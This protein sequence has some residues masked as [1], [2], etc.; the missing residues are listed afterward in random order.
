MLALAAGAG[1]AQA[2]QLSQPATTHAPTTVLSGPPDS[3][4]PEKT[5]RRKFISRMSTYTD[6]TRP[7]DNDERT[8]FEASFR[9]PNTPQ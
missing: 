5:L 6:N 1:L 4:P 9:S 2:A 3:V 8:C 7:T